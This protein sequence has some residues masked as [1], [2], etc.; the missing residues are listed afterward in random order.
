MSAVVVAT[1]PPPVTDNEFVP[2]ERDL[3]ECVTALPKPGCG[4]EAR[5]DWHQG[6]VL[7]LLVAGLFVIGWR[8]VHGVRRRPV[9]PDDVTSDAP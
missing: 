6:L 2:Q 3:G 7:A 1:S 4:S 8:I 5:S 9:Q